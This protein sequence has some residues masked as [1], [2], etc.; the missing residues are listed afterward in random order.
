MYNQTIY[1]TNSC[2]IQHS[3]LHF[4]FLFVHL[5]IH[6]NQRHPNPIYT[7]V[8][9]IES[10][11][12]IVSIFHLSFS[13]LFFHILARELY[14]FFQSTTAWYSAN[15]IVHT[16]VWCL[17]S[18]WALYMLRP[19]PFDM[20]PLQCIVEDTHAL[21]LKKKNRLSGFD[22]VLDAPF[23]IF[24]HCSSPTGASLSHRKWMK[25]Y[26]WALTLT[27]SRAAQSACVRWDWD[28]RGHI[29]N[30]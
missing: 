13:P 1:S 4:L 7:G 12:K 8:Q 23:V 30:I 11:A 20:N 2:R 24:L 17:L 27:W 14:I 5:K 18:T 6:V 29:S 9:F 28:A 3:I 15:S 22:P 10:E 25:S 19:C 26:S 16:L 21:F